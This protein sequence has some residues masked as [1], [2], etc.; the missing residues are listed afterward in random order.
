MREHSTGR[1]KQPA[2]ASPA[3]VRYRKCGGIK[4]EGGSIENKFTH[5]R[6][7]DQ[8]KDSYIVSHP[9]QCGTNA[10]RVQEADIHC[11]LSEYR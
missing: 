3:A 2:G 9:E 8:P 5:F 10:K 4:G 1:D 7:D 6:P 11:S